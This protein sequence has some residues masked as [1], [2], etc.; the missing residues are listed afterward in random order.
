MQEEQND[1]NPESFIIKVL[2]E[3]RRNN[4][5]TNAAI[6]RINDAIDDTNVTVK[7]L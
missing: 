1:V 2:D 7:N 3:I 4:D 5:Q 6:D